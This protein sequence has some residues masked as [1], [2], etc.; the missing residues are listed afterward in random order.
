MLSVG[1]LALRRSHRCECRELEACVLE[2]WRFQERIWIV[3]QLTTVFFSLTLILKTGL[4]N[5]VGCLPNLGKLGKQ[6]ANSVFSNHN[7]NLHIPRC[8]V[9]HKTI[10]VVLEWDIK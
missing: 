4:V 6:A 2:C 10:D 8:L 9:G 1:V 7:S 3:G 5:V